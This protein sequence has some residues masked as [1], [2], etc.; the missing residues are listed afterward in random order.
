MCC[1]MG[2]LRNMTILEE[3]EK[4]MLGNTR[5]CDVILGI[6]GKGQ[7]KAGEEMELVGHALSTV[8]NLIA[9]DTSRRY[10]VGR[11][12]IGLLF[13]RLEDGK[14]Q[15]EYQVFRSDVSACLAVVGFT[16]D[17]DL[18]HILIRDQA[19]LPRLIDFATSKSECLTVKGNCAAG[20]ANLVYGFP[21]GTPYFL[22]EWPR[23]EGYLREFFELVVSGRSGEKRGRTMTPTVMTSFAKTH[24]GTMPMYVG[25]EEQVMLVHVALWTLLQL[26]EQEVFKGLVKSKF[27]GTLEILKSAYLSPTPPSSPHPNTHGTVSAASPV[28]NAKSSR[29][30]IRGP[31]HERDRSIGSNK[32]FG[33]AVTGATGATGFTGL[34]GMT[35]HG[36]A[37]RSVYAEVR[38]VASRL[39]RL[40]LKD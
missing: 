7:G 36:R 37:E 13:Q 27:T 33:S 23:I 21:E 8:R 26:S 1:V 15:D 39:S 34:S 3:A 24:K 30:R 20:V 14:E 18:K 32:S 38:D 16:E 10:F 11:G 4:A 2:L 5:L 40:L 9:S 19:L 17:K 31:H 22:A 29:G 28:A 6:L 35:G 25:G 12:V